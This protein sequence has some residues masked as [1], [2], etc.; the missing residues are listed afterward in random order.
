MKN[1]I[2]LFFLLT[3]FFS[4]LSP[5]FLFGTENKELSLEECRSKIEEK[6][7]VLLSDDFF[8]N[9]TQE[10]KISFLKDYQSLKG[11]CY[12]FYHKEYLSECPLKSSIF[13]K[14]CFSTFSEKGLTILALRFDPF[15]HYYL[16]LL[17]KVFGDS[18]SFK[19]VQLYGPQGLN[20]FEKK[21]EK[22][23]AEKPFCYVN[24]RKPVFTLTC[25]KWHL[26]KEF[27]TELE[28]CKIVL[29][30]MQNN[31]PDYGKFKEN[32]LLCYYKISREV[33]KWLDKEFG[34]RGRKVIKTKIPSL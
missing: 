4:A 9:R 27:G 29:E 10:E 15:L 26:E 6:G 7:E 1:V 25:P 23:E 28:E 24:F 17:K 11:K 34:E 14:S 22:D 8:Y 31:I 12:S 32:E 33:I 3:L 13:Q 20:E 18:I 16:P 2:A 30:Y 5:A 21:T 19:V